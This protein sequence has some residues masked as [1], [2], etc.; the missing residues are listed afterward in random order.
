M[1]AAVPPKLL[2]QKTTL[3]NVKAYARKCPRPK[4]PRPE[5]APSSA[6]APEEQIGTDDTDEELMGDPID[7]LSTVDAPVFRRRAADPRVAFAQMILE[8]G[9][10]YV[11]KKFRRVQRY[12]AAEL[13]F[14]AFTENADKNRGREM[15][16]R[17]LQYTSWPDHS[18]PIKTDAALELHREISACRPEH[19]ILIHCSAGVGRSCTLVGV[20]MMLERV[21]KRR[22]QS[23]AAIVRTMRRS[24]AGAVQKAIQFLF[25]H[26]VVLDLFCQEGVFSSENSLMTSF[27]ESYETLI[28]KAEE[29]RKKREK[30][31]SQPP[32]NNLRPKIEQ[33]PT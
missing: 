11:L 32:K 12:K 17:H 28:I 18:S 31:S 25:M 21:L 5:L 9:A 6:P 33:C 16:V 30:E 20:E 22:F 1:A 24:R 8:Q 15:Q 14:R 10:L 19:P 2:G 27:R 13:T 29:L 3:K 4:K 23:G 7:M 26:Y